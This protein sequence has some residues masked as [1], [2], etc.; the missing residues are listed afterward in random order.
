MFGKLEI[1]KDTKWFATNPSVSSGCL[2]SYWRQ[3]AWK[4]RYDVGFTLELRTLWLENSRQG[5]HKV[6]RTNIQSLL[7]WAGSLCLWASLDLAR[8]SEGLPAEFSHS[9]K[10]WP[11]TIKTVSQISKKLALYWATENPFHRRYSPCKETWAVFLTWHIP[12]IFAW[13]HKIYAEHEKKCIVCSLNYLEILVRL[14]MKTM[15]KIFFPHE[16]GEIACML[17]TFKENMNC[18]PSNVG[19]L[20]DA[21]TCL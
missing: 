10:P 8:G 20:K 9:N 6:Q 12:N 18:P 15:Q 4:N 16:T 7:T 21:L 5:K 19:H 11:S 2:H 3:W 14:L 17:F 1:K 13:C